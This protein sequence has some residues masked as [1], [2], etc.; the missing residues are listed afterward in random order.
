MAKRIRIEPRKN[1]APCWDIDIKKGD[2]LLQYRVIDPEKAIEV[3]EFKGKIEDLPGLH[4]IESMK[5]GY[6]LRKR[7]YT[8]HRGV[9]DF[10]QFMHG[11]Q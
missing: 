3:L 7:K 6:S 8:I 1:L 10:A 11:I 9:V 5:E 2:L 4:T